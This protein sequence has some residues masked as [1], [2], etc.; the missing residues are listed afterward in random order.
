MDYQPHELSL[1]FPDMSPDQ[2]R[3]L[4]D[5]VKAHGLL[6]EIVLLDGLILD[7][8]HRFKACRES[9]VA[10]RFR[11][12]REGDP[13]EYCAGDAV[14]YV[15]AENG[16]RRHL[17]ESQ[18]ALAA[19]AMKPY[20]ERKARER[21]AVAGAIGGSSKGSADGRTPLTDAGR[22]SEKLA[23]K[24]G[25]GRRTIERAIKVRERGTP[26]LNAAV[27]SGEIALTQ[28][29]KIVQLNPA[30]QKKIVEAPKQQRAAE[31]R[32]A[33]NRSDG[34][35]RRDARR[36]QVVEQPS[37]AFVRKFLSGIE[38]IVMVCA[39]DE[40][41]DGAEI[42]TKFISEMDWGNTPLMLQLERSA[43][44]FRALALIQQHKAKEAA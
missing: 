12:F 13:D 38:R 40:A 27:A 30:A 28:A 26:E 4:V 17:S 8:R 44:L 37:T 6:H 1:A 3:R 22:V 34:C 11:H 36:N 33:V 15:T 29:E 9:G 19:A 7:G 42:A 39:E 24:V 25:V 2:F 20:E 14:A 41:K 35:R 18:I 10:P 23:Q 16:N 31:L 21:M 5:D 32:T 43:P